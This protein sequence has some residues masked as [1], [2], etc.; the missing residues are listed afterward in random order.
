MSRRGEGG[1][2]SVWVGSVFSLVRANVGGPR[3]FHAAPR[4][5]F[6]TCKDSESS[7]RVGELSGNEWKRRVG[8]NEHLTKSPCRRVAEK[9]Q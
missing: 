9:R 5:K 8:R 2:T 3:S 1:S 6:A 4:I 7:Y